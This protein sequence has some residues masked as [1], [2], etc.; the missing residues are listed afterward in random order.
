MTSR[1]RMQITL[2]HGIP[3][4]VPCHMNASSWIVAELKRALH[5]E[6]DRR[7]LDLLHIDTYDTRGIDIRS[8]TMPCYIGPPHPVLN[9]AWAGNILHLW[10]LTERVVETPRGN[11]YEQ[12]DYPL[13]EASTIEELQSYLWPKPEWFDY[14]SL[15]ERLAPWADRSI[16]ATGASVWQHASYVRGLDTL[17][18]DMAVEPALARYVLDRFSEFYLEFF[19]RIL[20]S[21]GDLIDC[22]AL[23]DDLGMQTSLM[24]SPQMFEDF[25]ADRIRDFADLV[26][27]Y[28]C[29]LI[30]HCDGNIRSIIPRLI[31]L[32]VD[33]LDPLQPE[34]EG[35]DPAVIK[36]EFGRELVLRG[37]ISTQQT[38]SRGTEA[39]VVDEVRRTIETLGEGGGYICSPGHPVLQ[40]DIPVR[41][42]IAMH[43]TAHEYGVY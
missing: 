13:R 15:P 28:K 33:V 5:A 34:A 36:R 38:L 4:R 17:M 41:N 14:R 1:E 39:E 32:G 31:D 21:A 25:V 8:G 6:E 10:A 29:K 40:S 26:H 35:M 23:A 3:D 42:I 43:E 22:C 20:E 24:I 27:S 2:D 7:L 12:E 18:I 37:G 30:F 19:R 9:E 16:I 11:L